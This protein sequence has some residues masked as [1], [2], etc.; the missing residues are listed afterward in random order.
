MSDENEGRK[1]GYKQVGGTLKFRPDLATHSKV[2][3]I[4]IPEPV[5]TL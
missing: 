3:E 5:L 1:E 2:K 4:T